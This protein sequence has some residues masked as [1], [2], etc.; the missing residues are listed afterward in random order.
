[1]ND[2]QLKAVARI[3]SEMHQSTGTYLCRKGELGQELF[4]VIKGEVEIVAES[5]G[6]P[7]RLKA[8]EGQVVGEFAILVDVPR[9]ADLRALSDVHLL[10][11]SSVRFRALLHQY[12]E[13]ADAVIRQLVMKILPSAAD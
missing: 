6:K 12:A 8:G 5:D 10:V 13:I 3:A 7:V 4:I 1:M 11:I 2:A 9:T